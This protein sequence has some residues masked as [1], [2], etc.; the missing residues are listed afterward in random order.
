MTIFS[1]I[2]IIIGVL[3]FV[4]GIYILAVNPRDEISKAYGFF[5]FMSL[6]IL[7]YNITKISP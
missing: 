4:F 5:T 7:P 6:E 1:I 3:E 2:L